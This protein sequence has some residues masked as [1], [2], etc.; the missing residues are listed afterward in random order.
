MLWKGVTER[1]QSRYVVLILSYLMHMTANI[2]ARTKV[3]R[4]K[5]ARTLT[6]VTLV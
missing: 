5:V 4:T 3:A 6:D 1:I 2:R